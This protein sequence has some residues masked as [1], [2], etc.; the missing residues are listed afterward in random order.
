MKRISMLI[1]AVAMVSALALPASAPAQAG[2]DHDAILVVLVGMKQD[3]NYMIA[4][5]QRHQ[6]G[7]ITIGPE[8]V[9]LTTAQQTQLLDRYTTLKAA[10]AAKYNQLP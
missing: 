6:A 5:V 1:V 9:T 4:L 3:I 7:A 10:L 2:P 8:M